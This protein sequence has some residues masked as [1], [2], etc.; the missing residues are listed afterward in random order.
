MKMGTW[1]ECRCMSELRLPDWNRRVT[2]VRIDSRERPSN[3]NQDTSM[4]VTARKAQPKQNATYQDVLDAPPHKV[5][6]IISGTLYTNPR[7]TPSHAW[8]TIGSSRSYHGHENGNQ[9]NA[10]DLSG[11]A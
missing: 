7:P 1:F 8:A 4:P 11:R 3:M 9:D 2:Q 6:E 10:G 5:A